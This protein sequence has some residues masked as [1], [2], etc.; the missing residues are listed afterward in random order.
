MV[1]T[2]KKDRADTDKKKEEATAA[3]VAAVPPP[4][5]APKSASPPTASVAPKDTKA[6]QEPAVDPKVTALLEEE[7]VIK[8]QLSAMAD[9][10]SVFAENEDGIGS[11]AQIMQAS[12]DAPQAS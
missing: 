1:A 8:Q 3:K 11:A 9:N 2:A 10:K 5:A 12:E 7:A 4:A 6:S